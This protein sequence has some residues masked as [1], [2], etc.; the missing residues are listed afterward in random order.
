MGLGVNMTTLWRYGQPKSETPLVPG[1]P[2]KPP[3]VFWGVFGGYFGGYYGV[4]LGIGLGC[5]AQRGVPRPSKAR[6][7]GAFTLAG[8]GQGW[9]A[10]LVGGNFCPGS[11][12]PRGGTF[13]LW[14]T[15]DD[16]FGATDYPT[17]RLPFA[18]KPVFP[19]LGGPKGPPR[20]PEGA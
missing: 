15:P 3:G 18:P 10:A 6:P 4:I 14:V 20:A 12:L 8:L 7:M 11:H 19:T 2:W 1:K 5:Q 13:V 9:G 16:I 17:R